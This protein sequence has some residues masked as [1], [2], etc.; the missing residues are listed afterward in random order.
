MSYSAPP[1][2]PGNA[3]PY[4]A[5]AQQQGWYAPPPPPPPPGNSGEG[6]G[7]KRVVIGLLVV[8][9][10]AVF[11]VGGLALY[12][13]AGGG[14]LPGAQG[15]GDEEQQILSSDE[16][17]TLLNGRTTALK[18]GNEEE[19]LEP[20][21]GAAKEKQGKI[22]QNL[23]KIPFAESKYM[24]LKQTGDGSDEWGSDVKL[25]LDVAFVH[26]IEGVDVRPV[27]E[28]YRWAVEKESESAEPRISE[29]GG[30]PG[31][32]ALANAVY[33]PAP[34]DLYDDM[35]VK[36]QAHTITVS[37]KKNAADAD[38]FAPVVEE[39]AKKDLELWGANTTSVANTPEG[40]LVV[41]EPDR[42]T[43]TKLYNNDGDDLGWDAGESVPMPA[44]NVGNG[45]D[46][47]QLQYGGAR[48]KMDS[49]TSRFTSA[50]WRA[51]V[52]DIS[53]H[54]IAHALVQPQDPGA[55]GNDEKT[56]IRAWVVEGFAE[57]V[58]YRFD[59]AQGDERVR[60]DLAGEDFTGELPGQDFEV[61][62]SSVGANYALSYLAMRFLAEK[63]GEDALFEFV[64]DHYRTPTKL[65]QQLQ[66]AVG[67]N[68]S[69]F[70]AAWA[71]Y[72]RSSI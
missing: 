32:A 47:E 18:S 71:Q 6:K 53:R 46:Q 5:P 31:A 29:V 26:Q 52:G 67:M 1:G 44:F 21:V 64:V 41:L 17:A 36:R 10:V 70:Q 22:F 40:F 19:F 11:G 57:Y 51:G 9:V 63:G 12:K 68:E 4:G 49:S 30:S 16:I 34:W 13:A 59:R 61:E 43:Y 58:S 15:G 65:D 39:S 48:I 33:Y 55:Y 14:S 37:A 72:V 20:F 27:S 60:R 23:R 50:A 66:R 8:A 38:R 24:V 3:G 62:Y 42:K 28:W 45:G 69:E 2:G 25:T 7:L 54:E 56:S 35:Y